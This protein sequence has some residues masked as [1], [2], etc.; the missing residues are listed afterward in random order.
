MSIVDSDAVKDVVGS[1][2]TQPIILAFLVLNAMVLGLIWW[3]MND[4][5]KSSHAEL[6]LL[7]GRCF[8]Y[9]GGSRT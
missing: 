6:Q 4:Q 9:I 5:S 8:D 7:M 3:T 1:L 2:K